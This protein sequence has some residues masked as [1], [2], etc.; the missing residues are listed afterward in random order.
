MSAVLYRVCKLHLKV[1]SPSASV[2]QKKSW[3]MHTLQTAK[4]PVSHFWSYSFP[5]DHSL[6][7]ALPAN[8]WLIVWRLN[9]NSFSKTVSWRYL[10]KQQV[11]VCGSW[12][13]FDIFLPLHTA[14]TE[15]ERKAVCWTAARLPDVVLCD[16]STCLT[17]FFIHCWYKSCFRSSR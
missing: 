10:Q 17:P 4:R 7:L 6:Q 9:N 13:D 12:P 14:V 16:F 5:I 8:I 1:G 2:I 15:Q 3:L 11:L